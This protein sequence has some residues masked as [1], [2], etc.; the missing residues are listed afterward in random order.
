MVLPAAHP[1]VGVPQGAD[2]ATPAIDVIKLFLFVAD[3]ETNVS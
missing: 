1:A 3:D 2:D